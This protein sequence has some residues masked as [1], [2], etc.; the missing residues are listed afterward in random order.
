MLAGEAIQAW[1]SL[2]GRKPTW[3]DCSDRYPLVVAEILLQ[4]TKAADALPIWTSVL[5]RFPSAEALAAAD[6]SELRG[7]VRG[8]GLGSQ[9]ASRLRTAANAIVNNEGRIPGIGTY[10]NGVLDL[11]EG[12]MPRKPPIDG[13]VARVL[14]RWRGFAFE[15]GEPRKKREL[16]AFLAEVLA[17]ALTPGR[18][19]SLLYALVDL[20]ATVCT[21]SKP[22]CP[23]CPLL[24]SCVLAESTR[25]STAR[26]PLARA[27]ASGG[28]TESET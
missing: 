20:G 7:L 15:R 5:F 13:N 12:R 21:P 23:E 18:A 11:A 24:P 4:K 26:S 1:G 9:R 25:S 6:L 19:L 17:T 14:T 10:G 8:L 28:G 16:A 2:H 27:V 22:S 3:R